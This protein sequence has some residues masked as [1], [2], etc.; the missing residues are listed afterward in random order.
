MKPVKRILME[1]KQANAIMDLMNK[2]RKDS[3]K[4]DASKIV[5]E[6]L[7]L[8]FRKYEATEFR[9][10]KEKFFD[11]KS[12]LKNLI[13]NSSSDDIDESIKQYL[14]QTRPIKKRGRKSKSLIN[15]IN[16]DE[17]TSS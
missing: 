12:F 13:N 3:C 11:K 2:M 14:S 16:S 15:Q 4:L 5:N 1:D 7:D 8:F 6:I 17:A 10:L 9:S